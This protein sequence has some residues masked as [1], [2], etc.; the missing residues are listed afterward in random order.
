[1]YNVHCTLDPVLEVML[2]LKLIHALDPLLEVMLELTGSFW[3]PPAF[4]NVW[5]TSI[6]TTHATLWNVHSQ[7][8]AL[9]D[10]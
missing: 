4:F 9:K 5:G 2:K 3:Q 8:N 6:Q 7:T 10:K 1:M